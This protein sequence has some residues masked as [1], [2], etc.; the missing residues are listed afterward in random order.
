MRSKPARWD[1]ISALLHKEWSEV[2]KNRLVLFTVA[3][4]PLIMT[5]LPLIALYAMSVSGGPGGLT[6][7]DMPP[8]FE[9]MCGKMTAS[10]CAQ[11]FVVS[12]FMLLFMLLPLAIP[13]TIAAYSIVGEKATRT[14]E[15]LLATPVSTAELLAGKGLAAALP[16]IAL[17]WLAFGIFA[18][19]VRLM[20]RSSEVMARLGDPLWLLAIFIVGPLLAWAAV[21]AAVMVSSRTSDPRVAEQISMLVILPLLAVFFGQITGFI[22]IDARTIL[23]L[24]AILFLLDAGLLAFAVRLFEREA[25]LTRWH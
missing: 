13:V 23:W 7:S 22:L 25:I 14:L 10:A 18:L 11:Y 17:T 15:P 6:A 3:F 12:Q 2:F 20:T 9:A 24:A 4:L 5:A 16:A 21:C 19:G 1:K 8:G